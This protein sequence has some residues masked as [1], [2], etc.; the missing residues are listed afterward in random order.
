MEGEMD[1]YVWDFSIDA[2]T[3]LKGPAP[4]APKSSVP[5]K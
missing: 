5:K 3:G 1:L 2:T 4:P